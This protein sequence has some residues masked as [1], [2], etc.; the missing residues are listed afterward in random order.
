MARK[1]HNMTRFGIGAKVGEPY[2][3]VLQLFKGRFCSSDNHYIHLGTV[4][5]FAGMENLLLTR[6]YHYRGGNWAAGGLQ[7]GI[8]Y[9]NQLPGT[10]LMIGK[11]T[12]QLHYGIG[13]QGGSRRYNLNEMPEELNTIGALGSIRLSLTGKGFKMLNRYWFWSFFAEEKYYKELGQ[14]FSFWR[15]GIGMIL[16]NVR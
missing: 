7:F 5:L 10:C 13:F 6:N 8:S 12:T 2:G 14:K 11:F 4:E 15:P 1:E 16:R 3:L 9:Q